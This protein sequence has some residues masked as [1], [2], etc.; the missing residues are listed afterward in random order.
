MADLGMSTYH[1]LQTSLTRRYANGFTFSLGYT[2]SK[3]LDNLL[4]TPRNPFNAALEKA[5]GTINRTHVFTGTYVYALPFGAGRPMNPDNP[6][7]R[8]LASD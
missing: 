7:A 8:A 3:E 2:F 5:P 4:G 1:A 6:V